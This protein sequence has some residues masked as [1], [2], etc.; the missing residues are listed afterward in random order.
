M[1]NAIE[2]EGLTKRFGEVLAVDHLSL[3]VKKGSIFGFLGPNGAGK[4][5]TQRLLVGLARPTEGTARI[6]GYDILTDMSKIRSRIGFL[7]DI[8]T[9]YNWMTAT[10][11]LN[12]VGNIFKIPQRELKPKV[13]SLLEL[14][15]LKGVKTKIGGYSRGMKQRLGI[16]QA[17]INEPEVILMDEPTSA[18]DPIGRKEVLDMIASLGKEITVFFSTH[19]LN[20]VERVCD[21]VAMLNRGKLITEENLESLKA[22]YSQP[23]FTME[24]ST[25]PGELIS[26][27]EDLPWVVAVESTADNVLKVVS[28]DL[29]YSERE[30]PRLVAELKLPLRSFQVAEPSLEEIFIKMMGEG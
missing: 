21:T 12:F 8:P 3:A 2:T 9:F 1:T 17:L 19:I 30:L 11:Y 18:L 13:E 26:K 14:A 4:T 24:F 20:D 29:E 22:R 6:L 23:T 5:T 16:A 10:D 27:L 15:G 7:P 25:D 28:K